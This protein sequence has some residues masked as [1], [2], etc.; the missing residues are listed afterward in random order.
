MLRSR[1][2]S[3]A[4]TISVDDWVAAELND[5]LQ[6]GDNRSAVVQEAI[7]EHLDLEEPSAAI[8]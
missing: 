8:E 4:I 7:V 3:E 5:R 6:Y 1:R 2:V